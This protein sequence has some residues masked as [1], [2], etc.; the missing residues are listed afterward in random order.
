MA[1]KFGQKSYSFLLT[2]HPDLIRLG[3]EAIASSPMDF[4]CTDGARDAETQAKKFAEGLTKVQFSKHQME[5]SHA[6]HF[7]P[8]P[9]LYP[10]VKPENTA[11]ETMEAVKRY[12]RYYML[13]MHI[14]ATAERIGIKIRWGGDWDGDYDVMDQTFDDLAHYE[15]QGT[16]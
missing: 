13:A 1:H 9:V 14:R 15:L 8:F 3:E 5:P 16:P 4:S 10:V 7:D 11:A 12:A 2:C 6:V